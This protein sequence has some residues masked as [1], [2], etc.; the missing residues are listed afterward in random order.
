MSLKELTYEHHRNAERQEFVKVLM[1]GSIDPRLYATFLYN[2]YI[3]YNILETVAMAQGVL[4]GLPDIR[5][6]PKILADYTELWGDQVDPPRTMPS[7]KDYADHIM[8]IATNPD[9]LMAHIYTRHMGDLSGGQMIR[10]KI[11]GKGTM[12]D[13]DDPDT[14]KTAIRERLN[15]NMADEAKICFEFATKLFQEMM[16][17]VKSSS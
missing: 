11:P 15:D 17:E 1:S 13:F 6:A 9:K 16:D 3:N 10:K 7:G 14:L 4:N 2:Q 12:F 5:R 8:S